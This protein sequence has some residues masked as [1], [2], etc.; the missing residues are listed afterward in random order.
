MI[1]VNDP[2][3]QIDG[4]VSK[5]GTI[6]RVF[7]ASNGGGETFGPILKLPANGTIG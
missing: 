5:N 1:A 6:V 2:S 7:R 3:I 4:K